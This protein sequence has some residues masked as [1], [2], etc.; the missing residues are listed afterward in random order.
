MHTGAAAAA[1]AVRL[2]C[3]RVAVAVRPRPP[4]LDEM[5]FCIQSERLASTRRDFAC[6][7]CV[8]APVSAYVLA[9]ARAIGVLL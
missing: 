8:P 5:R 6:R 2:R 4:R 9:V 3:V 1:L 7:W